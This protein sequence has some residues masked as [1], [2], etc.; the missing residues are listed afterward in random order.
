[1]I[2][3]IDNPLHKFLRVEIINLETDDWVFGCNAN[4]VTGVNRYCTRAVSLSHLAQPFPSQRGERTIFMLDLHKIK[5][6]YPKW[7]HVV[8]RFL[9]TS[10]AMK[11]IVDVHDPG[12]RSLDIT[13][14]KWYNFKTQLLLEDTMLG[15]SFYTLRVKGLEEAY[16]ALQ[17]NVVPKLCS[18]ANHHAV[19]KQ[20][21]P[22]L[23]GFDR[24]HFFTETRSGPMHLYA[25]ADKPKGY[26][27]SLIPISVELHLDPS[28]RY[29]I[30]IKNSLSMTMARIVQLFTH[31]LPAHLVAV[32]LLVLKNQITVT[33]KNENFKC[34]SFI[35]AVVKCSP[36]FIITASRVFAK[37]VLFF[38]FL[39]PPESYDMSLTVAFIIHGSA[40]ATLFVANTLAWGLVCF[41]GNTAH[42]ILFK[43]I[44]MP[45]P[46]ISSTAVNI[47]EKLPMSAGAFLISLSM[48]SC[49]GVGTLLAVLVYFI[50]LTKMYED[51]LEEFVFKTAKLIAN[52]LFGGR[53]KTPRERAAA[54]EN[55]LNTSSDDTEAN[56]ENPSDAIRV[57][58]TTFQ[59]NQQPQAIEA[60]DDD[61][62]EEDIEAEEHLDRMLRE[63]LER[64]REQD[65]KNEAE[66]KAARKEYDS[67]IEGL[68]EIHFHL[69]LF[70]LLL[71]SALLNLPTVVTWA[72]NYSYSQLLQ[73]DPT[74]YPSIA[75]LCSLCVI[76]QFPT[77]RN[78]IWYQ[79]L[80][81]LLYMFAV[82]CILYCQESTWLLNYIIALV[83][84]LIAIHQ[85]VAPPF[86]PKFDRDIFKDP[87]FQIGELEKM[88][89]SKKGERRKA[90]KAAANGETA[91]SHATA[92]TQNGEDDNYENENNEN[93]AQDEQTQTEKTDAEKDDLNDGESDENG[94]SSDSLEDESEDED[95]DDDDDVAG[96]AGPSDQNRQKPK[97]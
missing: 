1:M 71:I 77:P 73:P 20:C 97:K 84:I 53:R 26:N 89:E 75:I 80:S 7:T 3:L 86:K 70:F 21:V 27:T 63:S 59:H 50:L 83:F 55:N 43:I 19:A 14:P 87:R 88:L 25:A 96:A 11:M 94:S 17:L 62:T 93:D 2:R 57:A 9:P 40:L 13:M 36:F 33:P 31:W 37:L 42:K 79:H 35:G 47:I 72:K 51:Y 34:G 61:K 58:R 82:M 32:M 48:A 69:S 92:S 15:A 4:E 18:K 95:S 46:T 39:P 52:K 45:I 5:R 12:D 85:V 6:K 44:H 8:L 81:K 90:K 68:S 67:V 78:V 38:K 65:A 56:D 54:A 74:I 49:G 10:D 23:N 24:Y 41:Y 28:C 22:W 66:R 29:S 60:D 91:T 30:S 64:Y 16:Q 76:W